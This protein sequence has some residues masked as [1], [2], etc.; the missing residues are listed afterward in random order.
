M[1]LVGY[2]KLFAQSACPSGLG[3]YNCFS[4]FVVYEVQVIAALEDNFPNSRFFSLEIIHK[5]SFLFLFYPVIKVVNYLLY[6][7]FMFDKVYTF[8]TITQ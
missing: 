1:E 3:V 6:S 7:A 2:E 8:E 4:I 5:I